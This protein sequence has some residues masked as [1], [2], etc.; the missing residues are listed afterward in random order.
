M[1]NQLPLFFSDRVAE[2]GGFGFRSLTSLQLVSLFTTWEWEGRAICKRASCMAFLAIEG[3][4][5]S[6]QRLLASCCQV[7]RLSSVA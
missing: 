6:A 5:S 2:A 3:Q 4:S 7:A 1:I